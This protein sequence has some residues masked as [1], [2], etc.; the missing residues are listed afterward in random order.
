MANGTLF[1]YYKTKDELIVALYVDIKSR[2]V[3]CMQM[4]GITGGTKEKCKHFYLAAL[5]WSL[6]NELEL[7][8]T[9]QFMTSPYMQLVPE[10]IRKQEQLSLNLMADGIEAGLIKPLPVDFL[11]SLI[12]SHLSGVNQ[13]IANTKL[14]ASKQK[15][16]VLKSFDLVWEMIAV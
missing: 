12:T 2:L 11:L 1:H 14:T 8:F 10:Q 4:E 6:E 15:D 5:K 9:Q 3:H 13:Y 7:R 16:L